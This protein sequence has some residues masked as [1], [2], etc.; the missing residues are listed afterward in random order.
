MG[1]RLLPAVGGETSLY[2][3]FCLG[4]CTVGR[5][6][7]NDRRKERPLVGTPC[8]LRYCST[9]GVQPRSQNLRL[10]SVS[11]KEPPSVQPERNDQGGPAVTVAV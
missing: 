9:T 3:G 11:D 4:R 10:D 5:Q 6:A 7:K 1:G 8:M 2:R